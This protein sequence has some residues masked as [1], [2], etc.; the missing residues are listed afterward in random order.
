VTWG[1]A[2][3]VL[4]AAALAVGFA[5][6]ERTQPGSRMLAL[7]GT[8]A[9]LAAIG[10]IAFAPFPNVKP[11]TDIVLI[12]GYAL[13]GAPGFVVGA[14]A[15]L[16]S[17]LVFGQ[18][19]WTPWQMAAWGACGILGAVIGRLGGRDLGRVPLALWC[20]FAGLMFGAIMDLSVWATYSGDRTLDQYLAL[21]ATSLPFNIAH[22]AGN[23]VFCLAF[24]PV[25]ARALMR[26][27]ARLEVRWVELPAVRAAVFGLSVAGAALALAAQPGASHAGGVADGG[28]AAPAANPVRA[29]SAASAA[30]RAASYLVR[31]QQSNG[32][33]GDSPGARTTY[34]YT[35]W[36]VIG[37]AA[38]GRDPARVRRRGISG[39]D[40]LWA[41]ARLQRSTAEVARTIL[42]LAAAGR[43]ARRAP[44]AD[45]VARLR[46]RQ[47]RD[48]SFDGL[49]NVT[50]FAV[51]GLRAAGVRPSDAALQRAAR[52]L[53]RRQNTDGGF[54][55]SGRGPSGI[56]DSAGAL[57][58]LASVRGR[59]ARAVRRAAAF[60]RRRQNVDGGYPLQPRQRSNA[61]STAFAV[62]ALIAAGVNPDRQR[63]H[64]S[65]APL[66][67]LRSLQAANGSIRYSRTSAQTP[68]WVTAQ[69][70]AAL[71][72]RPL[73]LRGPAA[74]RAADRRRAS[75]IG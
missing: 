52:A 30:S 59:H 26:Y 8:L 45:L 23:V 72:R 38:A 12:S 75:P 22:A 73:P 47:D 53:E 3:F 29:A 1:I 4:L 18:G 34:A 69:A 33:W 62:Q 58:A 63:T 9:A 28:G 61:Q 49:V 67:Y 16:A 68:V 19:P 32:A 43:S 17:N 44:G 39:T 64:G 70:L 40:V 14:V 65:R 66:A 20:G 15:A 71:A 60:L 46:S 24:G 31:T 13:G 74:H 6:Y 48:G 41:G 57:E 56:D 2:S 50:A 10:R 5:W 37:L 21:A 7:V 36:S 54:N 35:T 25:L 11:T 27:R 55:F 42:G 51:L